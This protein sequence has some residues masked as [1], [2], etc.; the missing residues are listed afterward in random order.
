MN[1]YM[2]A[3]DGTTIYF[4]CWVGGM[5]KWTNGTRMA[6]KYK[7]LYEAE[8]DARG[9]GDIVIRTVNVESDDSPEAAYDRAMGI[10]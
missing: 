1:V 6:Y 7:S 5:A 3:Q 9:L 8:L 10:L 2:I 4:Q